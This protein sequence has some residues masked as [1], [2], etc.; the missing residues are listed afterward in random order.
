MPGLATHDNSVWEA[1]PQHGMTWDTGRQSSS[2]RLASSWPRFPVCA[3][4]GGY[5]QC[6]RVTLSLVLITSKHVKKDQRFPPNIALGSFSQLQYR[7]SG[8]EWAAHRCP[9][10]VEQGWVLH[11]AGHWSGAALLQHPARYTLHQQ[12]TCKHYKRFL[13]PLAKPLLLPRLGH[14][15]TTPQVPPPQ[16]FTTLCRGDFP[17]LFFFFSATSQVFTR[18]LWMVSQ[19]LIMHPS[20]CIIWALEATLRHASM[21]ERSEISKRSFCAPVSLPGFLRI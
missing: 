2:P 14:C 1:L 19:C 15:P 7:Y 20:F 21:P 10:L 4:G 11:R 17:Y 3:Q 9:Q 6:S 12:E 8:A 13:D 18:S 5:S 16:V